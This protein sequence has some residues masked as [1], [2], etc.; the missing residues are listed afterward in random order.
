M[1]AGGG[2]L[3]LVHEPVDLVH[4]L[5]RLVLQ[6]VPSSGARYVFDSFRLTSFCSS[7]M[8]A[9]GLGASSSTHPVTGFTLGSISPSQQLPPT[10]SGIR[11]ASHWPRLRVLLRL[12]VVVG[13]VLGGGEGGLG[14]QEAVVG[15]QPGGVPETRVLDQPVHCN[16]HRGCKDG[17]AGRA[18]ALEYSLTV[19]SQDPDPIRRNPLR[20]RL[21]A[22]TETFEMV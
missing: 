13:G 21:C 2:A 15:Q 20:F 7:D 9:R 14:S 8:P 16:P 18:V 6:Q 19:N 12:R 3:T 4:E 1:G 17:W 10:S 5:H 11:E 22:V